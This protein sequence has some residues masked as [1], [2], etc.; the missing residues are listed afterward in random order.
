LRFHDKKFVGDSP[1]TC[2][3]CSARATVWLVTSAQNLIRRVV[4]GE[5][6]PEALERIGVRIETRNG[7]ITVTPPSNMA[8]SPCPL[9]D[10]A[11][12]LLVNW[13]LGTGLPTW[14]TTMLMIDAIQFVEADTPQEGRLLDAL[15]AAMTDQPI[16]DD[17]LE[18]ARRLSR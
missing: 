12:G 13:A 17:A 16:D 9:S 1:G 5:E 8:I 10:L 14:A 7:S 11:R 18:L 2:F 15:W 3:P 6:A 4:R